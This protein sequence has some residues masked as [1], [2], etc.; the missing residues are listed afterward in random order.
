MPFHG[1]LFRTRLFHRLDT[2][3]VFLFVLQF[4]CSEIDEGCRVHCLA[5]I[6]NLEVKVTA[7]RTACIAAQ[8]DYIAC[9]HFLILIHHRTAQVAVNRLQSV[10]MTNDYIIAVATRVPSYDTHL[11]APCRT[12]RIAYLHLDIR[13]FVHPITAPAVRTG[14]VSRSR[15]TKTC[16]RNMYVVLKR[17]KQIAV[18]VH[19]LIRPDTMINTIR[20]VL[21]QQRRIAHHELRSHLIDHFPVFGT[22]ND[23][24][25]QHIQF[26]AQNKRVM[27][28]KTCQ[29]LR[30]LRCA[31]IQVVHF[32]QL[33][34][35]AIYRSGVQRRV[36]AQ[37]LCE[38][39]ICECRRAQ[40]EE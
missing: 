1:S 18:R 3:D 28:E 33:I 23:F 40:R 38:H 32:L 7:R 6:T 21:C 34:S 29:T 10:I 12:N 4:A 13:S 30:Q 36:Q 22:H 24:T 37:I 27:R 35:L 25:R 26:T 16:H 5:Q 2:D 39:V 14:H 11:T 9:Q 19:A 8:T 15:K 17:V 20:G 31:N